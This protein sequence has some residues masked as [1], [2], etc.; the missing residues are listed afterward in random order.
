MLLDLLLRKR[1]NTVKCNSESQRE[2]ERRQ[3]AWVHHQE[4]WHQ[5]GY[6]G[7]CYG[8][9]YKDYLYADTQINLKYGWL[10]G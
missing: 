3:L 4:L 1:S 7:P 5:D 2:G 10:P 9:T 8:P 6:D